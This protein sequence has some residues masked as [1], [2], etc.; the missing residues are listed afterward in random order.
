MDDIVGSL[1][2][3]KY[4]DLVILGDDPTAIDPMKI[5]KI[6]ISETWLEGKKVYKS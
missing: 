3:G 1:E 4:A 2:K 5:E 6:K